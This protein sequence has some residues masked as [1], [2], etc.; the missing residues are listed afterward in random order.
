MYD[1]MEQIT[2]ESQSLAQIKENYKRDAGSCEHCSRFWAELEK[3]K[4][5]HINRLRGLIE[6][7]MSGKIPE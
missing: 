1:L 5:D 2:K 4:E 7:H 6:D 3:D